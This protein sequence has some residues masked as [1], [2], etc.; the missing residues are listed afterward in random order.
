MVIINNEQQTFEI[1]VSI[2][3]G[4][5]TKTSGHGSYSTNTYKKLRRLVKAQVF[6]ELNDDEVKRMIRRAYKAKGHKSVAGPLTVKVRDLG[7]ISESV[8]LCSLCHRE[9]DYG[10]TCKEHLAQTEVK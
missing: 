9:H 2:P 7:K 3:T 8:I 10:I 6:V 1:E 4:R 5:V